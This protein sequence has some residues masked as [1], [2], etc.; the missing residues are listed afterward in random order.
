MALIHISL[1]INDAEYFFLVTFGELLNSFAFFFLKVDCLS[2]NY[3]VL[4]VRY[5]HPVSTSFVRS[6]HNYLFKKYFSA[7]TTRRATCSTRQQGSASWKA[8]VRV[9]WP[10]SPVLFLLSSAFPSG[11]NSGFHMSPGSWAKQDDLV[12]K[13]SLA[14]YLLCDWGLLLSHFSRVQLYVT[15]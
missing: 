12:L 4:G 5:I 2:P 7:T 8:T 1:M 14:I 13:S 10:L 9:S 3:W 11:D 15:P 6:N